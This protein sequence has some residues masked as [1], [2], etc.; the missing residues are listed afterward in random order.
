[1]P[2]QIHKRF[3]DEEIKRILTQYE[4]GLLDLAAALLL[5]KV[6]RS[7]FFELRGSWQAHP[8]TFTIRYDRASPARIDAGIEKLILCE[9]K[10]EKRLIDN[11]AITIKTYNYSAVRDAIVNICGTAPSLH[12]I[13]ARARTQGFFKEKPKRKLHDRVVETDYPGQ[14][15]QHDS[16]LH[17]W[18][19]LVREKWY[20][21]TTIDDYSRKLLYAELWERETTWAHI[22][23]LKSVIL[24]YGIPLRYYVDNLS[25]FRYVRE[26]DSIYR[27]V[28]LK[29][30]NID[31]Q[32][33]QVC[34]ELGI[35]VV[36]ALSPQAKGKI[37]RP[38]RW[39]QDRLVRTSA[40]E[41]LNTLYAVRQ[42]L[43]HIVEQYNHHWVHS[44]TKEVPAIRFEHHPQSMFRT[45]KVPAPLLLEKDVFCLR[46]TRTVSAYR[47]ISFDGKELTVPLVPPRQ[48]VELRMV[49]VPQ[50]GIIEV[51]M[52][53]K[54]KM[55]RELTVLAKDFPSVQF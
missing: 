53:F 52:W 30:D 20:L 33:K 23:A 18:S 36:Y 12:T 19:P 11:P 24:R 34:K 17:L 5:L 40:K 13:I 32:W 42:A 21:I 29:T 4:E 44:T 28:I 10:K 8:N 9:L 3:S 47:R 27:K 31:P 16:S 2:S 54:G 35:D 37:E 50:K 22:C 6:G 14:L 51:R 55:V 45:F 49:P 48:E 39:L 15:L 25:V 38:Y 7:R 46:Q 26:R 1:M 41:G 43:E